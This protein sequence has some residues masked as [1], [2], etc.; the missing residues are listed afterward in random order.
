[1]SVCDGDRDATV[2]LKARHI[3]A[4][5]LALSLQ[6]SLMCSNSYHARAYSTKCYHVQTT[7]SD[8]LLISSGP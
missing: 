1:V 2:K 7:S 4:A 6:L 8:K 3:T 5:L